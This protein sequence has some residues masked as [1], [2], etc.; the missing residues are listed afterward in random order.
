M[1]MRVTAPSS[2]RPQTEYLGRTS[3]QTTSPPIMLVCREG[4][5]PSATEMRSHAGDEP[6]RLMGLLNGWRRARWRVAECAQLDVTD[7]LLAAALSAVDFH[8]SG[9]GEIW[10][11]S[12]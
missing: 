11:S 7:E 1:A 4:K 3:A 12:G 9:L 5:I 10:L 6:R 2:G 8:A